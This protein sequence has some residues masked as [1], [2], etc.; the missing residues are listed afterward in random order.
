MRRVYLIGHQF[1]DLPLG[2]N[3]QGNSAGWAFCLLGLVDPSVILLYD[4]NRWYIITDN[5]SCTLAERAPIKIKRYFRKA[6]LV[7]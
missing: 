3:R 6:H 5:F 4:L 7:L 1:N 2:R